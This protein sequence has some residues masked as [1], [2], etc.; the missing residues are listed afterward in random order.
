M[1]L[2]SQIVAQIRDALFAGDLKTGDVLGSEADLAKLF[3]VSR[4]SVRDALRSLEAMGIVDIRMGAKGGATIA[5][6]SGD[7]FADSLAIQLKLIGVTREEILQAR[8]GIESMTV[9]M[10]TMR[11]TADDID[12][13]RQVLVEAEK[14]LDN[15]E[16]S[17]I[18]G[19]EFHMAIAQATRN[20][21]LIGQLRAMREVL[22]P[23]A[24]W[25]D[26]DQAQKMLDVHLELFRFIESGDAAAAR[27]A[28]V[29]HVKHWIT[30]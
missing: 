20:E 24:Q 8:A 1:T 2:S 10:A 12:R 29:E 14:H 25:P 30:A 5:A 3:G 22:M 26:H 11:G 21:V 18:L 28:M 17:A 15:P 16:K 19:E 27:D 9:A 7:R 4:M 6:G 23:P 13:I